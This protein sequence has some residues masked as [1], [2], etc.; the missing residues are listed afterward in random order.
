MTIVK[1]LNEGVKAYDL[2]NFSQNSFIDDL[3]ISRNIYF[4]LKNKTREFNDLLPSTRRKLL[5]GL[6]RLGF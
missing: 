6:E 1:R 2:D 3:G 5:D 4:G